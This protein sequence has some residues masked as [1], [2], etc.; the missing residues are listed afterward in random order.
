MSNYRK[1]CGQ[2]LEKEGEIRGEEAGKWGGMGGVDVRGNFDKGRR[3]VRGNEE[4]GSRVSDRKWE[5]K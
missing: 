1:K 5:E 4:R 2:K 3:G